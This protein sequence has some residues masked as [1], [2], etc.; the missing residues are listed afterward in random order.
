MTQKTIRANS[1]SK[2]LVL[3]TSIGEDEA[4]TYDVPYGKSPKATL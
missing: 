3:I 2:E 1:Y 4:E